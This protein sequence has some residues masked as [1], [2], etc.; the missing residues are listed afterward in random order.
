MTKRVATLIVLLCLVCLGSAGAESY[1]N[2]TDRRG[3]WIDT[4]KTWDDDLYMCWAAAASN[5][6]EWG[7]WEV[8]AYNSAS[9]MFQYFKAQWPDEGDTPHQAW[10]WW[11]HGTSGVPGGGFWPG[12]NLHRVFGFDEPGA[13]G[14]MP[15]I[16]QR[17]QKGYGLTL[18]ISSGLGGHALTCWGYE[19]DPRYAPEDDRYYTHL[20]VTDSDDGPAGLQCYQ[21]RKD[22]LDWILDSGLLA[23]WKIVTY[24]AL[25]RRWVPEFAPVTVFVIEDHPYIAR[26][27][28][29]EP[30]FS[31]DYKLE[32]PFPEPE[33]GDPC[34]FRVEILTENG[35]MTIY[36][37]SLE[38]G[39]TD[40][41]SVNIPL[42]MELQGLHT[43]LFG[44]EGESQVRL[45]RLAPVPAPATL[46][47]VAMGLF[48]LRAFKRGRSG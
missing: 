10:T 25:D 26:F 48:C 16:R 13:G 8:A 4:N 20:Y 32:L 2:Y 45:Y 43:L 47:L 24:Y 38:Q 14:L 9:L 41:Q 18:S 12:V 37:V 27:D 15:S 34:R 23:G 6:L 1:F 22:G 11:M 40:W 5:V 17:L 28:L 36:E 44:V 33:P 7:R 31:F 19:Y 30:F 29:Y 21:I 39:E 42:P 35:W 3:T 46:S